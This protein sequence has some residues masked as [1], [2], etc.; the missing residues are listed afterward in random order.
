MMGIYF[1]ILGSFIVVKSLFRPYVLSQEYGRILEVFVLSYPNFCE[2]IVG[3]FVIF[4][5]LSLAKGRM[6]KRKP[7]L[8]LNE[9]YLY[10]IAIILAGTFVILQ[11]FKIHNLGGTNVYDPYD[12]LFSVLGL[13]GAYIIL[14]I[15]KPEI[16]LP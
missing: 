15:V 9:H 2:A 14:R 1:G 3:S 13:I 8:K 11:E 10:L 12:V 5:L 6:I 16:I 7:N 4:A